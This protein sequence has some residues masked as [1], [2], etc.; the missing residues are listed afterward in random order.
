ME[1]VAVI[2]GSNQRL[3]D[4]HGAVIGASVTPGFQKMC[5]R[6]VPVAGLGGLVIV[7]AEVNAQ[8]DLQDLL[9]ELQIRRRGKDWIAAEDEQSRNFPSFD[10]FHQFWQRIV[11]RAYFDG[12]GIND[13]LADVSESRIHGMRKRVYNRRLRSA[14]YNQRSPAMVLQVSRHSLQPLIRNVRIRDTR[15]CILYWNAQTSG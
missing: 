4:A 10:F 1:R 6:D 15:A 3:N 8:L 2:K 11:F 7:E 9:R 5:L 13:G 14:G 12:I